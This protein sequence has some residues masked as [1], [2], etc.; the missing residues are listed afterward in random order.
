MISFVELDKSNN[1]SYLNLLSAMSKLSRLFSESESPYLEYRVVE[2]VFCRSFDAINLSRS[3]TAF[4]ANYDSIGVGIKTFVSP[5]QR[6]TEKVAEFNQL[7]GELRTLNGK[8]LALKLAELRNERINLAHRTYG[9]SNSLYHI[10]ARRKSKLLIFETDYE[11]IDVNNIKVLKSSNT[12]LQFEDGKNIYKFNHSKST[13]F[14]EFE[15]PQ[16][17]F[18]LSVNILDDPYSLILDLFRN[19]LVDIKEYSIDI[20]KDFVILPLYGKKDGAKYVYPKSGLN[21]WNASGRKRDYGEVYIPIP[22][23]IHNNFPDFFPARD[24]EFQL[25]IPT[26]EVFKAKI[27]QDDSKALMTNPNKAMSSWLLRNI[28]NL[29]EGELL[30]IEKM[31]ELGFDSMYVEKINKGFYKI[32][33]AKTDSYEEFMNKDFSE[34]ENG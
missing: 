24:V 17:A 14:R 32:D 1:A 19:E 16:N 13:L 20:E 33:I 4:D 8:Y 6:K 18:A 26:G 9:L 34:A 12:S 30:T 22:R 25:Q 5:N 27:C 28:F 11:R 2:N 7:A 15:I 31:K 23:S 29:E 3:D 21:Q 10:V